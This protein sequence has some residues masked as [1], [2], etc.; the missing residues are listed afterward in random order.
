[1]A[2]DKSSLESDLDSILWNR[3]M[4]TLATSGRQSLRPAGCMYSTA[5]AVRHQH[6]QTDRRFLHGRARYFSTLPLKW[7]L[8]IVKVQIHCEAEGP[9]PLHAVHSPL[10]QS[11]AVRREQPFAV[12]DLHLIGIVTIAGQHRP[13]LLKSR[14][15]VSPSTT[16]SRRTNFS[17]CSR[18]AC[19][20][21]VT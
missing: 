1:M 3:P 18:V 21:P 4:D 14:R 2:D 17:K 8:R 9:G 12:T 11:F 7:T 13:N 20:S 16:A 10:N 19:S 5:S 15:P 6:H